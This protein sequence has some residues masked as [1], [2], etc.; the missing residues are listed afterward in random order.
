[1]CNVCSLII[2]KLL[3]PHD[4]LQLRIKVWK[5]A[6]VAEQKP[7]KEKDIINFQSIEQDQIS[8]KETAEGE[9]IPD[10]IPRAKKNFPGKKK[11]RK[12]SKHPSQNMRTRNRSFLSGITAGFSFGAEE[13]NLLS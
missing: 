11:H 12:N 8:R 10:S 5:K 1:M 7:V 6:G 3:R 13:K 2:S 4:S 9:S